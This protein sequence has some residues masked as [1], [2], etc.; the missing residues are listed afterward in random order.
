MIEKD[1]RS[2]YTADREAFL[3]PSSFAQQRLWFFEQLHP[4]S[5][6]YHL[7]TVLP[8]DG[9]LDR[10]ALEDSL[11][12]LL[13][14][15]EALR[16][17]FAAVDGVPVQVIA[18]SLR[19][20]LPLVDVSQPPADS[21]ARA[22]AH[23]AA[24][25]TAPFDL[26]HGPLLRAS[27]VRLVSDYHWLVLVL[28]HIV[29]DGW[30]LEILHRDLRALYAGRVKGGQPAVPALPALPA[31]PIQYADFACWQRRILQGERL[32]GLFAYWQRQLEDAPA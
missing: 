10:Q 5:A 31:L 26:V 27:L 24:A 17:T 25:L 29:A 21:L 23:H 6:V 12:D 11:A 4:G 1:G 7:S 30:S 9:P 3:F 15:H 14:R 20:D 16:T 13:D 19:I 2:P 28:H 32:D 8:F 18:P 22:R